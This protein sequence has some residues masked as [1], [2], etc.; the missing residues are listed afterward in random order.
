MPEP[1]VDERL[2]SEMDDEVLF[3]VGEIWKLATANVP[4]GTSTVV[5]LRLITRQ[6]ALLAPVEHESTSPETEVTVP[7]VVMVT[8]LKS[9]AE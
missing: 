2:A 6:F 4:L 9:V 8:E 7:L 3:V 1:S 5:E